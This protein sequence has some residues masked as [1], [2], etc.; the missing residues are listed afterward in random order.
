[1]SGRWR[2]KAG[3]KRRSFSRAKE[4][5]PR[6]SSRVQTIAFFEEGLG[7]VAGA[8]A[9]EGKIAAAGEGLEMAAGVGDPVDFVEGV[10]EVGYA[11][12]ACAHVFR[13]CPEGRSRVGDGV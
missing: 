4:R 8:D 10:G 2:R 7:A 13:I 6:G 9:E 1:M 5:K 11:G 12:L 3:S